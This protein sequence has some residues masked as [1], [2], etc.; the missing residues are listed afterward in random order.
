[1][2]VNTQ[3]KLNEQGIQEAMSAEAHDLFWI[4]IFGHASLSFPFTR[5]PIVFG[6]KLVTEWDV[7]IDHEVGNSVNGRRRERLVEN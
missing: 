4:G 3:Y 1:M 7:A 5:F 2:P 6:V